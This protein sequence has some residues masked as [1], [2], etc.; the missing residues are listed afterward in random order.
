MQVVGCSGMPDN[1]SLA[2]I[3]DSLQHIKTMGSTTKISPYCLLWMLETCLGHGYYTY[4]GSLTVP[5]YNECVTWIVAST[6][7]KISLHQ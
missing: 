4:P 7:T 2:P 5:P 1:P 6:I 3:T